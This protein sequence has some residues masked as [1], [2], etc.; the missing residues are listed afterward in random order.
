MLCADSRGSAES[1]HACM[2]G[3]HSFASESGIKLLPSSDGIAYILMNM[4]LDRIHIW[5]PIN[6]VTLT[7]AYCDAF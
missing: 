3:G 5:I 6:H 1:V 7:A 2:I 4:G